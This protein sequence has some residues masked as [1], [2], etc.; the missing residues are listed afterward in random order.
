VTESLLADANQILANVQ[1]LHDLGVRI[2]LD[3]FGTGFSSL[4]R[5]TTLP[6]DYVKIDRSFVTQIKP[7]SGR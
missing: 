3:D 5:F 4:R 2:A 1:R 7:G 6:V